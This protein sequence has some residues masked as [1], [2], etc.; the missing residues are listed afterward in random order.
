M[1]MIFVDKVAGHLAQ[2]FYIT[3]CQSRCFPENLQIFETGIIKGKYYNYRE[4]QRNSKK[5]HILLTEQNLIRQFRINVTEDLKILI[6]NQRDP[7]PFL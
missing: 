6:L 7:P 4:N 3:D 5:E 2:N 1:W